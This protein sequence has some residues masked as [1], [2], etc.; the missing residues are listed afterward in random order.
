[1]VLVACHGPFTWGKS[2]DKAVDNSMILEKLAKIA[3]LT[4]EINPNIKRIKKTL[5]DKH[6]NRKHGPNSY[7]GQK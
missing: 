7:Y 5:V 2:A 4:V 6:F 1:M 3:Y